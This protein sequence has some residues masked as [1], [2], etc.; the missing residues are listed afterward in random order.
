MDCFFRSFEFVN[1][2]ITISYLKTDYD[3]GGIIIDRK[4]VRN[5]FMS[6]WMDLHPFNYVRSVTHFKAVDVSFK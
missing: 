5:I 4:Y 6:L 1:C 2:Y 3:L